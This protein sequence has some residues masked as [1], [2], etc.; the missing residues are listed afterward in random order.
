M[1]APEFWDHDGLLPRLLLPA[2]L[3]Y[4]FGGAVK[5]AM[6][7]PWRAPVPVVCIGNLTLG[8]AGKT[9]VA[10]AVAD[11]LRARGRRVHFLIR[12][13]GGRARGPLLVD[14]DRHDAGDV[15]DEAL[16]LTR[17]APTWVGGDR[18]RSAT[19]AVAAGADV[20]VMDDGFQNRSLAKDLSLVV[21]DLDGGFG[22]RRVFPAG[23]LREPI[24]EGL[25]RAQA[26]VLIGSGEAPAADKSGGG[27][28]VLRARLVAHDSALTLRGRRVAAF[29]GIGRPAKF[30][31][32]LDA[33]GAQVV[34]RRA[35]PDH[36]RYTAE[37]IMAICE[38]AAA[39]KAEPVTTEKDYVRLD[40]AMRPMVRAAAVSLIFDDPTRLDTLLDRYVTEPAQIDDG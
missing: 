11:R 27:L 29:A 24:A 18:R 15:G 33:I 10:L 36:Y 2:A 37:D 39:Q 20:L 19:A 4:R 9:P 31:D 32:T 25:R 26:L 34:V 5:A 28:P 1:R 13:Y 35:F 6:V 38:E 14:P 17:A 8:G 23:P 21:I 22:N 16:L 3:L 12:G 30:F 7:K 40:P